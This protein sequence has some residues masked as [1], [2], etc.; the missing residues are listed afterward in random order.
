MLTVLCLL[1]VHNYQNKPVAFSCRFVTV[2]VCFCCGKALRHG[3]I[4]ENTKLTFLQLMS[5]LFKLSPTADHEAAKW[6]FK[7]IKQFKESS[8]AKKEN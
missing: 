1:V 8:F 7:K 5:C 6:Q 2:F 3:F 4:F